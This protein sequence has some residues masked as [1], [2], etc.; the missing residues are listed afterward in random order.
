MHCSNVSHSCVN[1]VVLS[2]LTKE[3]HFMFSIVEQKEKA[4]EIYKKRRLHSESS[5]HGQKRHSQPSRE[6]GF[7]V[8]QSQFACMAS[9]LHQIPCFAILL[10]RT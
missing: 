8:A 5:G 6:L 9:K 2:P 7:V 4:K 3:Y 10:L 1:S